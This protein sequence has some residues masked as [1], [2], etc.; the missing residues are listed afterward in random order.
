MDCPA[1]RDE[2]GEGERGDILVL[3][4]LPAGA[5]V[6]VPARQRPG[7]FTA[8]LLPF[9]CS[10]AALSLVFHCSLHCPF[11]AR[12]PAFPRPFAALSPSFRCP[13]NAAPEHPGE[14][15]LELAE[16]D[17]DDEDDMARGGRGGGGMLGG[18]L[19][20]HRNVL[21]LDEMATP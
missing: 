19:G 14:L 4:A 2:R 13:S 10:C 16:D 8:L 5:F 9:G 11:A 12:S 20:L 3:P 6:G 7:P 21:R 18:A 1:A 17:D 15:R